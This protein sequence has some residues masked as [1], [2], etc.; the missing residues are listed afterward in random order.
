MAWVNNYTTTLPVSCRA[1]RLPNPERF[2]P[3]LHYKL[4]YLADE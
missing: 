1:S 4:T 3:C 2:D